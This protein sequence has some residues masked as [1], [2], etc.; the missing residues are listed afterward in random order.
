MGNKY[1]LTKF[2][3]SAIDRENSAAIYRWIEEN[4]PHLP[5]GVYTSSLFSHVVK[6]TDGSGSYFKADIRNGDP[7]YS[8]YHQLIHRMKKRKLLICAQSAPGAGM[9]W[10]VNE[11]MLPPGVVNYTGVRQ[12]IPMPQIESENTES[13]KPHSPIVLPPLEQQNDVAAEAFLEAEL[14]SIKVRSCWIGNGAYYDTHANISL[15]DVT[16]WDVY[17]IGLALQGTIGTQY[18]K[19]NKYEQGSIEQQAP[20]TNSLDNAQKAEEHNPTSAPF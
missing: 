19:E 17:K 20:Q 10:R 13:K 4:K 5:R 2:D 11:E 15:A 12:T 18:K 1:D 3:I 7:E 16:L 8:V 6:K 9:E 14:K